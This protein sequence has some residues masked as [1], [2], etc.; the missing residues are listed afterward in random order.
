MPPPAV[1]G[2]ETSAQQ[3]VNQAGN[4]TMAQ[5]FASQSSQSPHQH[6]SYGYGNGA[7]NGQHHTFQQ[8]NQYGQHQQ[9]DASGGFNTGPTNT[10]FPPM[11]SL[12]NKVTKSH[13][14]YANYRAMNDPKAHSGMFREDQVTPGQ[15]NQGVTR[16]PHA[17]TGFTTPVHCSGPAVTHHDGHD[18]YQ[19]QTTPVTQTNAASYMLSAEK[20]R[21]VLYDPVTTSASR[22][23]SSHYT[24]GSSDYPPAMQVHHRPQALAFS[25]N[26]YGVGYDRPLDTAATI[27]PIQYQTASGVPYTGQGIEAYWKADASQYGGDTHGASTPDNGDDMSGECKEESDDDRMQGFFDSLGTDEQAVLRDEWKHKLRLA[28][29]SSSTASSAER[30]GKKQLQAIGSERRQR[31]SGGSGSFNA[32]VNGAGG[33]WADMKGP[34][35][36]KAEAQEVAIELMAPLLA[37]LAIHNAGPGA[38]G[39]PFVKYVAPPA[40]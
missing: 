27:R 22:Q 7:G 17:F 36:K 30:N 23:A 25:S 4:L 13:G 35:E 37:N 26:I 18:E 29:S 2:T 40:W 20:G 11:P 3:R 10:N 31:S 39:N 1:K 15:S 5:A 33:S 21:T 16:D 34:Q 32:G 14:E 12:A 8:Q 9:R 24:E 38:A 6:N 28:I 19:G